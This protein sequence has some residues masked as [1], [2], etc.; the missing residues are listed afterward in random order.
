[1]KVGKVNSEPLRGR[2]KLLSFTE[3]RVGRSSTEGNV[4]MTQR[5]RL[6]SMGSGITP[7]S[8]RTDT[9]SS[10]RKSS[11]LAWQ[12]D[13]DMFSCKGDSSKSIK[14]EEVLD[15]GDAKFV[16]EPRRVSLSEPG[17]QAWLCCQF[18][19]AC[20]FGVIIFQLLTA[21]L[22]QTAF[23]M[24]TA[25]LTIYVY[26]WTTNMAIFS[27]IGAWR[28]RRD[29]AQDW[30]SRPLR[31][32]GLALSHPFCLHLHLELLWCGCPIQR[33]MSHPQWRARILLCMRNVARC[34][35]DGKLYAWCLPMQCD[36][37]L[38]QQPALS[39]RWDQHRGR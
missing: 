6:N 23:L 17:W 15:E 9:P 21:V 24:A 25:V 28:M 26:C 4:M 3:T 33:L 39:S 12:D 27:A 8:W 18:P 38:F 1:M 29:C 22:S 36:A 11:S 35:I 16:Q 32:C 20:L 31:P 19:G 10:R 13:E 5:S 37:E 30:H 34:A 14:E 2:D 7:S